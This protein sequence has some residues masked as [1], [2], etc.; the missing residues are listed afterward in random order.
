MSVS[1]LC[2]LM[3]VVDSENVYGLYIRKLI[4]GLMFARFGCI[5]VSGNGVVSK[6]GDIVNK[7]NAHSW[8]CARFT[9]IIC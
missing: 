2:S 7:V 4:S 8:S 1:L 9:K 3:N 5:T 6:L